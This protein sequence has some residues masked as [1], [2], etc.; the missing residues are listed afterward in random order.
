MPTNDEQPTAAAFAR[1]DEQIKAVRADL[2]EI[3]VDIHEQSGASATRLDTLVQALNEERNYRVENDEMLRLQMQKQESDQDKA[4]QECV[5]KLEKADMEIANNL[6][7]T[8]MQIRWAA[9]IVGFVWVLF[10]WI[11]GTFHIFGR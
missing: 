1:L 8:Q 7:A 5:T 10:Q 9:G 4:R 2:A 6:K 3:K 11:V